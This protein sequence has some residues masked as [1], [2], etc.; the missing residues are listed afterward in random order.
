MF[1][2]SFSKLI[3][4]LVALRE[5]GGLGDFQTE[6]GMWQGIGRGGQ[7]SSSLSLYLRMFR[8]CTILTLYFFRL[9]FDSSRGQRNV[10]AGL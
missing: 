4:T 7:V 10:V 1:A 3:L 5:G 9:S 2:L 8:F 6:M